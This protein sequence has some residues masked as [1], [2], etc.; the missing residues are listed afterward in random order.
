MVLCMVY[1]VY[2]FLALNA[3]N[4]KIVTRC[5]LCVI[6]HKKKLH[7]WTVFFCSHVYRKK[8]LQGIYRRKKLH[9]FILKGKN[10]CMPP[11]CPSVGLVLQR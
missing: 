5:N 4:K 9:D 7:N 10:T 2:F 1:Y 6:Y 3:R 8:K 11:I